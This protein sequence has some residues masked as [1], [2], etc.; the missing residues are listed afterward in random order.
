MQ[1]M[2]AK[3]LEE[4]QV[5]TEHGANEGDSKAKHKAAMQE[6]K[7]KAG[8]GQQI[9]LCPLLMHNANFFNMRL[10]MLFG[11]N[12]RNEQSFLSTAK[13]TPEQTC[14]HNIRLATG[15]GEDFLRLLWWEG[16]SQAKEWARLGIALGSGQSKTFMG[17][18]VDE[19]TG[20]LAPGVQEEDIPG[21]VASF[22]FHLI[23]ARFWSYAETQH[24]WP[25]AFAGIL[26]ETD[27]GSAM[28]QAQRF[29][30]ACLFAE[31]ARN[32][33]PGFFE[34]REQVY[35]MDWPICQL[36]FRLLSQ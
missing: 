24:R 28:P 34:L 17:P 35:W 22:M 18:C 9:V 15:S 14:Q 5:A 26:S 10:I 33:V 6:I 21:L 23:E 13:T 32:I 25:G 16:T 31:S 2:A 29:W 30:E 12:L 8:A 1:E 27:H 19:D 11:Q 3:L 4:A 20:L 36:P 7:K